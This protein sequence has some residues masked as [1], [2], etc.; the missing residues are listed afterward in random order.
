MSFNKTSVCFQAQVTTDGKRIL[1][2]FNTV[3]DAYNF[4]RY[5]HELSITTLANSLY[6]S[7]QIGEN[8][9]TALMEY[10][11]GDYIWDDAH[12]G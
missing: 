7:G 1:R 2:R 6:N 11:L 4:F 9:F 3:E 5:H 8:I 10:S 12:D